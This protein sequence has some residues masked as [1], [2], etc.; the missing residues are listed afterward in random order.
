[1]D[2]GFTSEMAVV[3]AALEALAQAT[4]LS[5]R[6]AI[7]CSRT[8]RWTGNAYFDLGAGKDRPALEHAAE[9]YREAEKALEVATGAADA[10]EWVK[11]NYCFGKA[12]LQLSEGKDLTLAT[13]ARTRL[14]AA[15]TLARLHM[16]DGVE[17][18]QEDLATAQKIVALLGEVG[19]LD[20]RMAQLKNELTVAD[21]GEPMHTRRSPERAAEAQDISSMFDVLSQQFEKEK[22]SLDPTRQEGL[23]SLMHRLQGVVQSTTSEGLSLEAMMANSGKVEALQRELSPQARKPSLKGPGAA[24]GSRGGRLLAA[25]QELK[26]FIGAAGMAPGSSVEMR[27]AA[28]D[29]FARLGRLTTWVSQAGDDK[30]KIDTLERDQARVLAHEVRLYATRRHQLLAQPVWPRGEATV[31]A[32]RIFFSGST[33]MRKELAGA[34]IFSGLELAADASTGADFATHRWQE[35]QSSNVAVFDL[36][37]AQAQVYY[38]LGIALTI[39]AQILLI[40]ADHTEI[41]FDIAQNVSRYSPGDGLRPWLA[42]E[43]QAAIY[44]LQVKGGKESS[45]AATLGYAQLI[46]AGEPSNSLLTVAL[47]VMR[48]AGEDPI[49][50]RN[51]LTTFNTYLGARRHELLQTR[52][53]GLYPVPRAPRTFAVMPFRRERDAAYAVIEATA[54]EAGVEPVRG[55]QAEGQEIIES[56]WQEICRATH[57]T[58]D[59]SG[60]NLNV[61]LELG[62]ADALGR[63]TLLIGEQGTERLVEAALPAVAKRRCHTYEENPRSTP[64]FATA[65]KKFFA[66]R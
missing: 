59:L 38:E 20:Q 16:P 50:F 17:S 27:E 15:L 4:P 10:V 29:L 24:Q 1:M 37:D 9:A 51:A 49:R 47:T 52:W 66:T 35:L 63:R 18:V 40:A 6:D 21:A 54:R 34:L 53:R 56:I 12:L 22:P 57:V 42:D 48:N 45:L 8:W 19:H 25:L 11:L 5:E 55:D 26:M 30:A 14:R 46:A 31:D 43:V 3:A 58:V 32:N 23:S 13:D 28:M 41:P 33:R 60:F 61:C 65:L 64:Q 36:S 44:G 2:P 7:E 39:G 62:M